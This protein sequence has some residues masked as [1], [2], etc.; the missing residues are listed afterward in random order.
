MVTVHMF[1]PCAIQ[2]RD[3]RLRGSITGRLIRR[4]QPGQSRSPAPLGQ[5]VASP[6]SPH[7][8]GFTHIAC[9]FG[10]AY[11]KIP[12]TSTTKRPDGPHERPIS[13]N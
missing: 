7:H 11:C 5:D 1:E 8:G 6:N 12:A 13:L 4:S 3:R 2:W 9:V 10:C